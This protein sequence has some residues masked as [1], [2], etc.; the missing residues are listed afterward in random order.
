[1]S[2][3]L[4]K[5][6]LDYVEGGKDTDIIILNSLGEEDAVPASYFF[7]PYDRMPAI[8]Q[9]ALD[10][11]RGTVLDIGAGAG[12]HCLYLEK[13]G[14]KTLALDSSPEAI[15]CCTKRGLS[16]CICSTIQAFHKGTYDTLLMLMNGLGVAGSLS[17][18]DELLLHLTSLM[19]EKG[20]ILLDSSDIRYMYETTGAGNPIR[21][22]AAGYYGDILFSVYYDGEYE[23]PFPWVY[24]DFESLSKTA[25]RVGLKAE[26]VMDG[27]H[28]DYLAR[29]TRD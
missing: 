18:L 3:L 4:G 14:H 20:Q 21:P 22:E 9:K 19:N 27:P 8:E 25:Q 24:V 13:K 11:A 1:M 15:V 5:A 28:F 10:L 17:Q 2:R 29:L 26:K 7:R 16:H 23:P 12:S 6:L